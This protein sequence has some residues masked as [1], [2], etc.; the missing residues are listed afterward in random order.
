ME[1]AL[2]LTI[3]ELLQIGWAKGKEIPIAV[4]NHA[5]QHA[6]QEESDEPVRS[7][8]RQRPAGS[9]DVILCFGG[10]PG[11]LAHRCYEWKCKSNMWGFTAR[12]AGPCS[13]GAA[14]SAPVAD[15]CDLLRG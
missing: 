4:C 12:L 8:R 3:E 6:E 15:R 7:K 5:R 14:A 9:L 1:E 11:T 10:S 13:L 2:R